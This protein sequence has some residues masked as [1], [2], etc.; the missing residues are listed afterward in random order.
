MLYVSHLFSL[1][2]KLVLIVCQNNIYNAFKKNLKH[3]KALT[4]NNFSFLPGDKIV[5]FVV[6]LMLILLVLK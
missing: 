4:S 1:F 3:L 2:F 6:Y 5:D